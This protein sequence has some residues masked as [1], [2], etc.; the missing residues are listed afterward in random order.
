M[1]EDFDLL[2]TAFN[3][4]AANGKAALDV[5]LS[6]IDLDY[7]HRYI[8]LHQIQP[9][10]AHTPLVALCSVSGLHWKAVGHNLAIS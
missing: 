4:A 2:V 8:R 3:P 9:L 10:L 6:G 5:A 7:H 1:Q